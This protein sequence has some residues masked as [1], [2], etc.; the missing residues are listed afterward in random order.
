ML[1]GMIF[2]PSHAP[3]RSF[4]RICCL[5]PVLL[6]TEYYFIT[7]ML[8]VLFVIFVLVGCT[9]FLVCRIVADFC[10]SFVGVLVG[11]WDFC[12]VSWRVRRARETCARTLALRN[13][14]DTPRGLIVCVSSHES[15]KFTTKLQFRC[16]KLCLNCKTNRPPHIVWCATRQRTISVAD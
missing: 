1:T 11:R 8:N 12:S 15:A 5:L 4:K 6:T 9:V 16:S 14:L 7:Y 3:K 13:L 10:A 2:H